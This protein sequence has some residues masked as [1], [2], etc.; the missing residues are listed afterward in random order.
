MGLLS[1]I[2]AEN[3]IRLPNALNWFYKKEPIE[4]YW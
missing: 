1:F 3:L 2:A 4:T